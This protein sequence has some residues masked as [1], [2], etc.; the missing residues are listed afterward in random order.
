ML[1]SG[2]VLY[3]APLVNPVPNSP[4]LNLSFWEI[5][6]RVKKPGRLR[7]HLD[8]S[9]GRAG[10][11]MGPREDVEEEQARIPLYQNHGLLCHSIV[12]IKS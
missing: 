5:P 8:W 3:I 2:L 6:A 7:V 12:P 4:L 9:R 11:R 10:G 1:S